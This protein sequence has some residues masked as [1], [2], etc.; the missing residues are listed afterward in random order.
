MYVPFGAAGIAAPEMCDI[1]GLD[2]MSHQKSVKWLFLWVR[3]YGM[4][5]VEGWNGSAGI[6]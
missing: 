3:I 2:E 4:H 6:I 1:R 5:P